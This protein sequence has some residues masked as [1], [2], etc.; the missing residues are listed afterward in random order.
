MLHPELVKEDT[1]PR[2]I[3][4]FFN[5]IS[6]IEDFSKELPL[7]QMIGEGSVGPEFATMFNIFINN[8]LDK[9]VNPKDILLHQNEEYIIGQLRSC[10]GKDAEYRADI[11]S[12][13]T[14]RLINFT[15]NYAE[16]HSITE[17]IIGRLTTL[18]TDKETFTDDL[19]YVMI[20]KILNSNK[21]KFQKLMTNPEIIQMAMK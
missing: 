2:S 8:K 11:A 14:T 5:A 6:S 9:L 3:T 15:A 1:N 12:I 13:L 21:Q 20:K 7:I 16:H 17:K 4:N 19:K 18:M 10:I